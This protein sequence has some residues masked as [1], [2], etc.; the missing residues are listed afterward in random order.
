MEASWEA[1]IGTLAMG[2]T[3]T[4]LL[5]FLFREVKEARQRKSREESIEER[6]ARLVSSFRDALRLINEIE[7][8]VKERSALAKK[9][10]EDI[11]TYSNIKDLKKGEVEAVAQ[12]L[13]AELKR[14]SRKSFWAGAAINFLFFALG[15]G[16]SFVLK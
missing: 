4:I 9:L 7:K 3:L 5:E 15:F 12:V 14:E 8:N 13:R 1:I 2:G 11:A 16:A 10:E 6:M